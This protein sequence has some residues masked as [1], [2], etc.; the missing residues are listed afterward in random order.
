MRPSPS[1]ARTSGFTLIELI[2]VMVLLAIMATSLTAFFLPAFGG[3]I[4]MRSRADLAGQADHALRRM[5]R[6]VQ[7]AVPNS[8]RTPAASC[9]ELVPTASGGRF[10][11]GPDVVN[12]AA[13][14]CS[15]AADCAAPLD[16]T[17]ATGVFDVLSPLASTPTAGDWVVIDNQNP[18]DV[19]GGSNRAAV[20]SV[21][22][23]DARFGR[24]R[25]TVASTQFPPGYDGGRFVVVPQA[26]AA[27]FYV[28]SGADGTLDA[29]GNGR[30]TLYRA[31]NY[32][33]NASYPSSC[34]STSGAAVLATR[35]KSCRFVYDPNQGATQQSGFVSMQ[36]ELARNNEVASLLMGA[37][38]R[39]VP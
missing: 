38:V 6:D 32:G 4:G 13:P 14:G 10:R 26:Q 33:F 29:N 9:F 34:P 1:F 7:A 3:Y 39:N 36:L 16:V 24:S 15:P 20:Q 28:C 21:A 30:G 31:M 5:V 11:R 25:L 35:V 2:V 12:D 27:V 23:P 19:Y 17:R 18:G 8:I 22:T 37:H